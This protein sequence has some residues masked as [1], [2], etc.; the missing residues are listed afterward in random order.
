MRGLNLGIPCIVIGGTGDCANVLESLCANKETV[1]R[2]SYSHDSNQ[3]EEDV[4]K[5]LKQCKINI[6]HDILQKPNDKETLTQFILLTQ[7]AH[8]TELEN[9]PRLILN[10]VS[11]KT[12]RTAVEVLHTAILWKLDG[13]IEDILEKLC[14]EKVETDALFHHILRKMIVSENIETTELFFKKLPADSIL[15][16]VLH[17]MEYFYSPNNLPRYVQSIFPARANQ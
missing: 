12:M 3:K 17:E 6:S 9:L 16:T 11:S 10:V 2:Y 15:N 8:S 1:G 5:S 7:G 13:Y 14:F 4:T